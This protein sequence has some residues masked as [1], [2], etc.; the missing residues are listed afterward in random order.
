MTAGR[1]ELL[2]SVPLFRGCTAKELTEIDALVEDI[3]VG[4]GEVMTREGEHA[5]Q[6]YIVVAGEAV[7]SVDG[8]EITRLGPGSVFGEMAGLDA[9]RPRSATVTAVS[10][11]RLLVLQPSGFHALVT[12]PSVSQRVLSALVD[13]TRDD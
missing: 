10:P 12:L 7:V 1:T 2:A 4:A 8:L 3:D 11:M 5:R 6:S 9:D 13:R